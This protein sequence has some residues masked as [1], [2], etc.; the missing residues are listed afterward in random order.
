MTYARRNG[1]NR[2]DDDDDV[3]G[4]CKQMKHI[5]DTYV[6]I[7]LLYPD[8]KVAGALCV[9]RGLNMKLDLAVH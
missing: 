7:D 5:V 9:G 4:T 2:D 3:R 6:D 1:Y 8:A